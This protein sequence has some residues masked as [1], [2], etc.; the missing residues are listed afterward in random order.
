M[1]FWSRVRTNVDDIAT[2]GPRFLL[3]HLPRVT[4]A[5]MA[6]VHISGI[7]PI[8]LRAGESDVAA[9]RQIFGHKDYDIGSI[10]AIGARLNAR[11]RAILQG[12][13]K[14]VI[15]DAGA[16]VGT[17]A[18]WFRKTYIEAAI[19]AVEPEPG[20]LG[21]LKRNLEGR[22]DMMVLAAAIGGRSGFV[23]VKMGTLGWAAQT[24]RSESGVPIVTMADAFAKV[25][26][27]IPFIA[28][29]DIEGFESDLF[30]ANV[31][32]LNDVSMVIIEPHDWMLPGKKTSRSFQ[33]AMGQHDFEIF[34][35]GENL[36][37]IR[38]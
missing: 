3:R 30:S 19:V 18:L 31:E 22:R 27:G 14:P 33:A 10:P 15:V 9:V 2:F 29:I 5:E 37:Y 8:Y 17:A 25:A 7:G 28:K 34:I 13:R 12:G 20:N 16:N 38:V 35:S 36:I 6:P 32:W 11:Y 1:G 21:V 26:D 24:L 23:E 4:G